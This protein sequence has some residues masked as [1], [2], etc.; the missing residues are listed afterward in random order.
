MRCSYPELEVV[1]ER[2]QSS[3][4]CPPLNPHRRSVA[5][6]SIPGHHPKNLVELVY[7]DGS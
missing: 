5:E 4:T 6:M 1:R 7:Y 2:L 3:V